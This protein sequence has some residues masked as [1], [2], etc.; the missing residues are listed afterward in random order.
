MYQDGSY[1]LKQI[2]HAIYSFEIKIEVIKNDNY[3]LLPRY[4]LQVI[5]FLFTEF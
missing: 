3:K 1:L 4:K 2:F 5:T